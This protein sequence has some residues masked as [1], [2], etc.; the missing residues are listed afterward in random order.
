[1]TYYLDI[2]GRL[3]RSFRTVSACVVLFLL[4]QFVIGCSSNTPPRQTLP[5]S[6]HNSVAVSQRLRAIVTSNTLTD[7]RWSDFTDCR[8]QVQRLYQSQ[9]Y[10]PVWDRDGQVTPQAM[11]MIAALENSQQK[12]LNPQDYDASLWPSRLGALKAASSDSDVVARFDVALSV[13]AMRYISDLH[14]GRVNP[15]HLLFSVQIEQT[16]YDLSE[17]LMQKILTVGN[18]PDVLKEVEPQYEGYQR[19]ENALQ[20]YLL[21]VAQDNGIPLKDVQKTTGPSDAYSDVEPL[22]QRLRVRGDLPQTAVV[23]TTSG[24]YTGSLVDA[25]KHFQVRHGIAPDGKLGKETLRQLNTPL[26]VRV[27]QLEDA[28]ERWR[29]L[30]Q[31]FSTLPVAVNIPEFVLRVFSP[32][33][34]IAL[35]MNVVVGKAFGHKTPIFAKDMKYIIF[36]PY[37]NIPPSIVRSEILPGLRKNGNYLTRKRLEITDQGGKVITS[38]AVSASDLAQLQSGKLMVRQKPGPAN[39]LGLVKFM[40]PNEYNV[41]LHSTPTPQLFSQSRRDFSHGCIRVQEPAELAAFLLQN[42]PKWTLEKINAAMQ[43]GPDNQQVNLVKPVPVVIVYMTAVVEENGEVYFFDDIY[44]NDRSLD[45][46]LAKRRPYK[47]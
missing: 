31:N 5:G 21:L 26:S 41:Y 35:R 47:Q 9:S 15:N 1:V 40:F 20:K 45:D 37:W 32:D 24:L 2:A 12:G 29:W 14:I 22:A 39:A 6:V 23:D 27:T 33:H 3:S 8:E 38:G 10:T 16:K 36:R 7:L 30:P 17:F 18:V 25:V 28:M 4:F 43:S 34:R 11:A 42:Q 46:M 44:G 19:T 13:N